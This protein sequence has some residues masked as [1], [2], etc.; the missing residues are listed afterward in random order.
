MALHVYVKHL[1]TWQKHIAAQTSNDSLLGILSIGTHLQA[2]C[3]K[4]A[5]LPLAIK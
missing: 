5:G 3:I 2:L 1:F 4:P